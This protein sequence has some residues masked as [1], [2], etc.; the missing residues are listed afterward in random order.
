MM[1]AC[2]SLSRA[3]LRASSRFFFALSLVDKKISEFLT[4]IFRAKHA[5]PQ[6]QRRKKR[7]DFLTPHRVDVVVVLQVLDFVVFSLVFVDDAM[8]SRRGGDR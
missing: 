5:H 3:L 6:S 1:C 4:L 7:H 8:Q 2:V